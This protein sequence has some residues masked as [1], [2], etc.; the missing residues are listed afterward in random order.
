MPGSSNPSFIPKRN[1]VTRERQG[2]R[3]Q[4]YVGTILVRIGFIAV[5]LAVVAIFFYKGNLQKSLDAE[6]VGLS[7]ALEAFNEAELQRVQLVDSKLK[8]VNALMAYT[9]STRAI[10]EAVEDSTLESAQIV[11]FDIERADRETLTVSAQIEAPSFDAVLFQKGIYNKNDTLTLEKLEEVTIEAAAAVAGDTGTAGE[12]TKLGF[13]ALLLVDAGSVPHTIE[14]TVNS[15]PT[16]E[17]DLEVI[18]E[19]VVDDAEAEDV[20]SV[21]STNEEVL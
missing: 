11:S 14:E 6:V 9:V 2:S 19:S 13:S 16:I 10:L 17:S 5:L 7:Q 20:E 12:I 18:D 4:V 1:T 21:T 3:R 15:L 8:E